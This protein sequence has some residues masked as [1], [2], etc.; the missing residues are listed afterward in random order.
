[1]KIKLS[2]HTPRKAEETFIT[3]KVRNSTRKIALEDLIEIYLNSDAIHVMKEDTLPNIV[4][5]IRVVLTRI[6]T[7]KEDIMLTL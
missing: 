3:P 2:Q 1:M 6:R 7:I 5:E 4:L